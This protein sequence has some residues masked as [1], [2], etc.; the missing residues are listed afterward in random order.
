MICMRNP[1]VDGLGKKDTDGKPACR[2]CKVEEY[3]WRSHK[4]VV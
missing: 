2:R 3:G 4:F 1:H